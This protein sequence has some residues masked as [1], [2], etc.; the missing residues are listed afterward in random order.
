MQKAAMD[1]AKGRRSTVVVIAFLKDDWKNYI[2]AI[3]HEG[4]RRWIR[5]RRIKSRMWKKWRPKLS[6]DIFP[7]A[8][9]ETAIR[10]SHSTADADRRGLWIGHC[11]MEGFDHD[12]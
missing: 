8:D 7:T 11:A 9:C 6:R 5:A 12:A 3:F 1:Q 2:D 10:C 4:V